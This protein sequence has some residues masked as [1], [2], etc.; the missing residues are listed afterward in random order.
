MGSLEFLLK[1]NIENPNK[2]GLYRIISQYD[3]FQF[4]GKIIRREGEPP[5]NKSDFDTVYDNLKIIYD[6]FKIN[7]QRDSLDNKGK[8]IV[9][10]GDYPPPMNAAWSPS[11]EQIYICFKDFVLT[12]GEENAKEKIISGF[13]NKLDILAHEWTHAVYDYC[14]GNFSPLSNPLII[15]DP[16]KIA[17]SEHL[18]D[19]FGVLCQSWIDGIPR[20]KIG[21]GYFKNDPT[22]PL[23]S[24]NEEPE[25]SKGA[26]TLDE[27]E[28]GIPGFSAAV[29]HNSKILSHAFY[30]FS[31]FLGGSQEEIEAHDVPGKIWFELLTSTDT[32]ADFFFSESFEAFANATLYYCSKLYGGRID[33]EDK[34]KFAWKKVKLLDPFED[35][36]K[37][38]L[39]ELEYKAAYYRYWYDLGYRNFKY[40]SET[41]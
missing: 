33:Y 6:F 30:I 3:F 7:Y 11:V 8:A 13:G 39:L 29:Y 37:F 19:V 1:Q 4:P 5:V 22:V 15:V 10:V 26:L 12:G 27:F 20:W 21:L 41:V 23:R 40:T 14:S 25:S 16:R 9:I 31:V 28:Y 34:L 18:S 35:E 24:M 2:K 36:C 32:D 17:I 38:T